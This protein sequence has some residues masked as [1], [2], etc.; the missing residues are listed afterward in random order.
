MIDR[1][2]GWGHGLASPG[3][4]TRSRTQSSCIMHTT[5]IQE[6]PIG[7][8]EAVAKGATVK[9][10]DLEGLPGSIP[11]D[12]LVIV[13]QRGCHAC[14]LLVPHLAA[15]QVRQPD[16]LIVSQDAGYPPEMTASADLDLSLSRHLEVTSTPALVRLTDGH[17]GDRVEGWDRDAWQRL[18]GWAE[19]GQDLPEWVPG[20]AGKNVDPEDVGG[21]VPL[22]SRRLQLGEREDVHETAFARGW[23]DGL[24]VI[25]PTEAR[26]R[27]MLSGTSH[28][29]DEVIA[30]MP[31][32]FA[33]VTVEKVAVNAVMAGCRPEYLPV[34]LAAVS[35]T[36]SETFNIHGVAATT[37][38]VGPVIIVNGP[39]THAIGMN[40]GG[41]A[42]G[43]GNRANLT[44]GRAVSLIVRNIGGARPGEIDRSTLGSPGKL[45]FCFAEEESSS[46]WE[47]LSTERG[48]PVR[49]S[50]VTL[51][52]GVGPQPVV[53]QKSRTPDS[54][55]SS[56]ALSLRTMAHAKLASR[57]DAVVVIA[58]EHAALFGRAGWD[59]RRL[60]GE[61]LDRLTLP[62]AEMV[63][64]ADGIAE[65]L[66]PSSVGETVCKFTADGLW[67][68]HAGAAAGQYS[69]IIA[70]WV[71][72][73]TGSQMTT[74]EI[75]PW[76]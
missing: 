34:V 48:V 35:A 1:K 72:G 70:G 44:I 73:A 19:L 25:P 15:W 12:G 17:A 9:V 21:R 51:F 60:R 76:Q 5:T 36:A 23:S 18:S 28:E 8:P 43:P 69:A 33:E 68:V 20:C 13:I 52:A 45:S 10:V 65:G 67:F 49:R 3:R 62:A 74:V 57:S 64:G 42:L 11:R 53:D 32:A 27:A 59:K 63:A 71:N 61:I 16:I 14:E 54:L 37:H 75:E 31:P 29:A 26:V 41:N 39:V 2:P 24:P 56:L 7:A 22:Q 38:F 6:P 4:A 50:A 30:L 58:P 66:I 46:P 40:P 47:P 55:A